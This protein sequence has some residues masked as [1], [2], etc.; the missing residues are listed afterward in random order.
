[1]EIE[2]P[3]QLFQHPTRANFAMDSFNE[4]KF[5]RGIESP[6]FKLHVEVCTLGGVGEHQ[7][8]SS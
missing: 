1:M 2:Y 5:P 8:F 7:R 3:L 6:I 4:M